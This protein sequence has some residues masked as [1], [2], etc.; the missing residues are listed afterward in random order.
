MLEDEVAEEN[1]LMVWLEDSLSGLSPLHGGA[2]C[3]LGCEDDDSRTADI[4]TG[5]A[6]HSSSIIGVGR[7]AG[8]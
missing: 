5:R 8:N 7:F 6:E 1:F 2:E 3:D 4:F